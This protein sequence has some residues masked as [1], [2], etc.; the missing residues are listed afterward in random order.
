MIRRVPL[1]VCTL[2]AAC[3]GP[4]PA[5]RSGAQARP[6]TITDVAGVQLLRDAQVDGA[7]VLLDLR[8]NL[9]T[10]VN[11]QVAA[12]GF[13]PASTF[14]IPN[15][16]VALETGVIRDERFTLRWD[17]T[18]Q[19]VAAWQHDHDLASAIRDSVVWYYQE[20]ARRVGV[21]RMQRFVDAF[22]Y[23]NRDLGGG[24]D[25]FWLDGAL[26]ISPYEQ[27]EFLRRLRRGELPVSGA[28]ARLVQRLITR[29]ERDGVVLRG[30]TGLGVQ[31]DRAVGWLVGLVERGRDSFAY[32]MLVVAP[33]AAVNR[34]APLRE[35]LARRYLARYGAIPAAM[36][37]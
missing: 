2:L 20:V 17:G 15:T 13:I 30:K 22:G 27:V 14:K 28:H 34:V 36:A 29:E 16:L 35:L 7:F 5:V 33:R 3:G 32:A 10:V 31:G 24:I 6:R 12:R 26:R 1:V 23:G 25:R 11:P 9:L 18:A 4:G 19:R 21:Q 37:D 8:R